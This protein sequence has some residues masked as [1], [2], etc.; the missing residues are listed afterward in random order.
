[1]DLKEKWFLFFPLYFQNYDP[2]N[3]MM[4]FP[5]FYAQAGARNQNPEFVSLPFSKGENYTN[6]MAL[7]YDRRSDYDTSTT[8]F[9][10]PLG[11]Y[12]PIRRIPQNAP[13][14]SF[15][16]SRSTITNAMAPPPRPL[17]SIGMLRGL[18][19]TL[20]P[21]AQNRKARSS[22]LSVVSGKTK[23]VP[24]A[25]SSSFYYKERQGK[26]RLCLRP[27]PVDALLE[28]PEG[29]GKRGRSDICVE[30]AGQRQLLRHRAVPLHAF[31]EKRPNPRLL[32]CAR[33]SP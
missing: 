11:K 3:K 33:L 31:L 22:G 29:N 4:V 26:R 18:S 13:G 5:L 14:A 10:I 17:P 9:M 28:K 23:M 19:M 32:Y 20:R 12:S 15:P 25:L 21:M 2:M 6:V 27:L 24:A 8:R 16:S 7:A 1:M 30:Q